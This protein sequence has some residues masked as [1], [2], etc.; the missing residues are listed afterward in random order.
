[1]LSALFYSSVRLKSQQGFLYNACNKGAGSI[2]I[3]EADLDRNPEQT[4]Y[5]WKRKY[6]HLGVS[7]LQGAALG[8]REWSVEAAVA[9]LSLDK[10]MLSEARRKNA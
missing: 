6:A 5:A 10:L 2:A 8:G 1:M 7:N 4:F 9:D 3:V